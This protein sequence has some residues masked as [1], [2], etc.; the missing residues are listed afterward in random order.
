MELAHLIQLEI[1]QLLGMQ[2]GQQKTQGTGQLSMKVCKLLVFSG[3]DLEQ[4]Y[5]KSEYNTLNLLASSVLTHGNILP[6]CHASLL[7]KNT[8]NISISFF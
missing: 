6:Q 8:H 7:S 2:T 3:I 1:L 5:S 4:G